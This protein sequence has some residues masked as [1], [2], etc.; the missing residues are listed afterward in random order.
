MP[1][2]IRQI[3]EEEVFYNNLNNLLSSYCE[4]EITLA[5]QLDLA[6]AIHTECK[7]I[8]SEIPLSSLPHERDRI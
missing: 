4:D 1:K 6:D 7:R 5:E 8:L 3:L 2:K